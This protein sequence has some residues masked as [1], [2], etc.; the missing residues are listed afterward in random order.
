MKFTHSL[1]LIHHYNYNLFANIA[2]ILVMF[3]IYTNNYVCLV[4]HIFIELTVIA[5][6]FNI[7]VSFKL[8]VSMN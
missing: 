3:Y 1:T 2:Q 8:S 5:I 7:I 6:A 4:F